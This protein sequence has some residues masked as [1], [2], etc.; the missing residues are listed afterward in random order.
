MKILKSYKLWAA[1]ILFSAFVPFAVWAV[2]PKWNDNEHPFNFLFGNIFDTHQQSMISGN[3]DTLTGF[4]YIR[5]VGGDNPDGLPNAQHGTETVGWLLDG[6][7][8]VDA[9]VIDLSG[10]H[11][12]WCID[13]VYIPRAKGYSHFHWTGDPQSRGGLVLGEEK[14]GYVLKLTAIDAF[15]FEHG[16]YPIVPGID[17]DS[18]HNI[19][20]DEAG[21]GCSDYP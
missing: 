20:I 19:V 10:Q 2:G 1:S 15:F 17:Y 18:H 5:Y 16:G 21:T 11:P 7:P 4:F 14:D 9:K 3:Q 12:V 6:V 8:V 13:P